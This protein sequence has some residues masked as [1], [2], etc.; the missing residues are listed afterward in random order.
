MIIR[1]PYMARRLA[2]HRLRRVAPGSTGFLMQLP[3]PA[4]RTPIDH[5]MEF[6]TQWRFGQGTT[7]QHVRRVLGHTVSGKVYLS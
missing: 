7:S 6:I 1:D 3:A 4:Y 5:D 2:V